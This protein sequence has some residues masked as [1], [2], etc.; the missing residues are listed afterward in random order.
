MELGG[1]LSLFEPS[2]L[3][4]LM[5]MAGVTGVLRFIS[6]DKIASFYFRSG[7]LI[8]ATTDTRIKRIGEVLVDKGLITSAQLESALQEHA[9]SKKQKRIGDILIS[10]K[11][12]DYDS[13]VSV[14]Q[15]QMKEVVFD[16]LSWKSGLFFFMKG[17]AP[18]DEDVLLEVK[19][20]H[21]ILEGLK[22]L[23]EAKI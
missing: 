6:A 16:V 10:R 19:I 23:D 18:K 3:F 2:I 12:L 8:C 1:D 13:L 5:N 17:I 14:V 15:E 9:T 21:L 11:Y 7:E 4:Q 20:D 22:R